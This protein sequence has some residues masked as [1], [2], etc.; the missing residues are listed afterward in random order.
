MDMLTKIKTIETKKKVH[1]EI[2]FSP[3][4]FFYP[5]CL[6]RSGCSNR[7]PRA[8]WLTDNRNLVPQFWRLD[9]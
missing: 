9:V 3:I 2:P 4:T 1:P 8:E 5:V 6:V 7:I